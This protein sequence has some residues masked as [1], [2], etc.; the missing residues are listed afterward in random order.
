MLEL[1]HTTTLSAC[2]Q[3][4]DVLLMDGAGRSMGNTYSALI[5]DIRNKGMVGFDLS[6]SSGL[7]AAVNAA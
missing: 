5:F 1:C 6:F 3:V 7:F 4:E 2:L